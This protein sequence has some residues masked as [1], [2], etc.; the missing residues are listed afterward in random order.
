[1]LSRLIKYSLGG[2]AGFFLDVLF[3]N[4]FVHY[5]M[6]YNL[7]IILGFVLASL[8]FSYLFHRNV[9]FQV[10]EEGE[11]KEHLSK[12]SIATTLVFIVDVGMSLIITNALFAAYANQSPSLLTMID[13]L[14]DMSVVFISQIS[15]HYILVNLGKV[16]GAVVGGIGH[17][18]ILHFWVFEK[19]SHKTAPLPKLK[20]QPA[21]KKRTI[22]V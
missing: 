12:F 18:V 14:Q 16:L 22:S 9:T 3:V 8:I 11:H 21:K 6:N 19:K 2:L 1:M 5:G 15:H 17:Y 7:A 13:W 20:Q 4:V 10:Q